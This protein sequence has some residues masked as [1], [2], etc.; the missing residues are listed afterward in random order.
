MLFPKI[1]PSFTAVGLEDENVDKTIIDSSK[2]ITSKLMSLCLAKYIIYTLEKLNHP[3][4]FKA[5]IL[6]TFNNMAQI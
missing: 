2:T 4:Y 5:K 1:C 3:T 6:T